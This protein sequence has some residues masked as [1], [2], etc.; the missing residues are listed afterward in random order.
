MTT[1]SWCCNAT[2]AIPVK[3]CNTLLYCC[4]GQCHMVVTSCI[5]YS[6]AVVVLLMPCRLR[7]SLK[8]QGRKFQCV[9]AVVMLLGR[10][11]AVWGWWLLY[12]LFVD[13]AVDEDAMVDNAG[14]LT[15]EDRNDGSQSHSGR[16]SCSGRCS[17]SGGRRRCGGRR[18]IGRQWKMLM[19][20]SWNGK[21]WRGRELPVGQ[22]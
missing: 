17:H 21:G 1:H 4:C 7:R 5:W 3:W 11:L 10:S 15:G 18:I 16:R 2:D 6:V 22:Y 9:V 20:I 8:R 14:D 19:I 12:H 13:S